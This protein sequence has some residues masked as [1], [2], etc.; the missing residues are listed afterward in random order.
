MSRLLYPR[1]MILRGS[2]LYLI[3]HQKNGGPRPHHYAVQ[4]FASVRLRELDPWP[5]IAFSLEAFLADGTD[6]F[7]EGKKIQLRARVSP[8]LNKILRDAP[9]SEDMQ[10]A[11]G[12]GG[13]LILSATVRDTWALH[14][15]LLGHAEHVCVLQ[16]VALRDRVGRRLKAAAAH[17]L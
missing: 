2:T 15:W 5:D 17:Y 9:L 3:A 8:E 10:I 7:G 14:T 6:Q 4:R 13:E 16:P 1:A 12:K 11:A